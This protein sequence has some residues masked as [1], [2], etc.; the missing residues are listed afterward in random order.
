YY[1]VHWHVSLTLKQ[2]NA[3]YLSAGSAVINPVELAG[4]STPSNAMRTRNGTSCVWSHFSTL[5]NANWSTGALS[6]LPLHP[7]APFIK[8]KHRFC[9]LMLWHALSRSFN[10]PLSTV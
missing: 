6:Q 10:T 4:S 2:P 3:P 1:C 7:L 5:K 8:G 9:I